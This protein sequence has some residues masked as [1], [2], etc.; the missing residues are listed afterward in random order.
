MSY[1]DLSIEMHLRG[2]VPERSD[3]VH[4]IVAAPAESEPDKVVWRVITPLTPEDA[5]MDV[6]IGTRVFVKPARPVGRLPQL[7]KHAKK[8]KRLYKPVSET[9][10]DSLS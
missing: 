4:L 8:L 7:N 9:G 6:L 1:V 3:P 2:I 5:V 10:A